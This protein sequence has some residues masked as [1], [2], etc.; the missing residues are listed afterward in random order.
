MPLN[1]ECFQDGHST[2]K[3]NFFEW[4]LSRVGR[5]DWFQC[6][7]SELIFVVLTQV[8]RRTRSTRRA[9]RST[10]TC[11]TRARRRRRRRTTRTK[12]SWW[13]RKI[14]NQS[15]LVSTPARNGN[16]CYYDKIMF[17]YIVVLWRTKASLTTQKTLTQLFTNIV[18]W[19]T[20]DLHLSLTWR[21]E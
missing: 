20:G 15:S 9:T 5:H 6:T 3:S 7:S 21:Q 11:S 4:S 14:W 19:V 10:L 13:R 12:N 8:R 16:S 2:D 1:L 18:Y 17:R